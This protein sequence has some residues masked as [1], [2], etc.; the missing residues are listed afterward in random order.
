MVSEPSS[1]IVNNIS[2]I[3]L[4]KKEPDSALLYLNMA[5]NVN[6]NYSIAIYNAKALAYMLKQDTIKA[7]E[8]LQTA[9]NLFHLTA[10]P[11]KNNYYAATQKNFGD[12]MLMQSKPLQALPFYQQALI[13]YDFNFND[14]NVFANPGNFIGEFTSYNLFNALAAK[15]NCLAV[16]FTDTKQEKYF[17][18]TVSTYDSAFALADYIKKSID[19]D[20]AR[21]FIADKVFNTYVQAVDFLMAVNKNNN[22][23]L[24]IHALEWI[25]K[26]RATSLTISLKEN[27]IKQYAGIPDSLLQK[28][29]NIKI[30][31]SRLKL[32]LQRSNNTAE[33][34]QLLSAINTAA[35]QL[36]SIDNSFKKFPDYFKEK[37]AADNVDMRN[38]Q[39]NILND[40]TAVICYSK[41][42]SK[43][44]T[45]IIRQGQIAAHTINIDSKFE[46]EINEY[47]HQ[48]TENNSGKAYN[49]QS[50]KFLYAKL[51]TPVLDDINH[52][53]SLIIIPDKN[54]INVPFEAFESA[55]NKYLIQSFAVTYQYALPLLQTNKTKFSINKAVAFAPFAYAN[56]NSN[57]SV[58]PASLNEISSF[59][60]NAQQIS[61]NATK[62]NF[63]SASLNASVI[64]LATHAVVNFQEPENSYIVFYETSK[65]DSA[66]KIFAHELYNLQL[67]Q[68]KLIFLSAC[69]TGSGKLSQS[70]GALSLSRAFAFAGCPNIITSLW[71][72]EDNSTAYISKKFYHYVD[73]GCS[74][75]QALQKAKTD[76]LNDETMSQFHSPVYWSHLIFVGDVP[77]EKTS[78]RIWIIVASVTAAILLLFLF[79][80]RKIFYR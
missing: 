20:E 64:H 13:Q 39:K 34:S 77:Q 50:A 15:A 53:K 29:Q 67:P 42:I 19:N 31:I 48:L 41:G 30:T 12:L 37:F 79:N 49:N 26:S 73:E 76:L 75:A 7:R 14:A 3:Y 5:K 17:K 22:E 69:E 10:Q 23:N 45:F 21:S 62:N 65:A 55:D 70:E 27:T 51:I 32:Q 9:A 35:L 36:Q 8:N 16:I 11:Q 33:Q 71:K 66:Y 44:Y 61:V 56:I 72:A 38:I 1:A 59:P 52:I 24:M 80:R 25:S 43:L 4:T 78:A 18:A 68:T 58:L 40:E 47:T 63:F 2:G 28:E 57:M 6:D 54:L 46:S 74:Y 60:K